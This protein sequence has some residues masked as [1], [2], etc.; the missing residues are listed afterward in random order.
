M[1]LIFPLT[2]SWH[3]HSR[4][5]H[6]CAHTVVAIAMLLFVQACPLRLSAQAA[7]APPDVLVLSNGD[8][9]HGKFV[10]AINGK[11]T[12]HS[13][14]LGD[15]TLEWDKIKELH[16]SG[17]FAVFDKNVKISGKKGAAAF[18]TGTLEVA[19]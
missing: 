18:P 11:V 4:L 7:A 17:N 10:N 2:P 16:T 6:L 13:D 3:H 19:E 9:L 5:P 1:T 12:F 8:T 15:V 14:P